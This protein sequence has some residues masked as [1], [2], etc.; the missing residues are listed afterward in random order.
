MLEGYDLT[1]R[2]GRAKYVREK[3][4]ELTT[5]QLAHELTLE[6]YPVSDA[7][8]SRYET[9]ERTVPWEYMLE[10]AELADVSLDWIVRGKAPD[11]AI[12]IR[13]VRKM[14]EHLEQ[15]E[16]E[17]A[18]VERN[19]PAPSPPTPEDRARGKSAA[20]A[21]QRASKAVGGRRKKQAGPGQ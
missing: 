20:Q 10:L 5:V 3:L 6:G 1:T 16:Q 9:G 18:V 7:S 11:Q 15:I 14:K 8:V 2:G 17:L 19:A 12:G 4:L 13:A 21:R